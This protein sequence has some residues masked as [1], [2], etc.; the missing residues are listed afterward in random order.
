MIKIA[1]FWKCQ[2]K[3][4]FSVDRS[5]SAKEY[6]QLKRI[7]FVLGPATIAVI[8]RTLENWHGFCLKT[9]DNDGVPCAPATAHIGFLLRH[10]STAVDLAYSRAKDKALISDHDVDFVSLID[11]LFEQQ[12]KE[13]MAEIE[14]V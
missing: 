12:Y 13:F 1:D 2:V 7:K 8:D 9:I 11:E 4:K 3:S 10:L 5:L 6:G 14:S